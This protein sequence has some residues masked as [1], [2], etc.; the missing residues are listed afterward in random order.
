MK[1]ARFLSIEDEGTDLILSFALE[2]DTLGVRSLILLRTPKFEIL[3]PQ[4][5]RGVKVFLEGHTE[6]DEDK[7]LLRAILS[8]EKIE[9]ITHSEKYKV[10]LSR[11]DKEEL[12]LVYPFLQKMNFDK[13]FELSQA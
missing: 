3:I 7:L 10:D 6:D 5:E 2:D 9:L 12:K 13:K 11:V 1:Q 4:D 8:S